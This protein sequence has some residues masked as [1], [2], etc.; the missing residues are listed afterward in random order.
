MKYLFL[1]ISLLSVHFCEAP[2]LEIGILTGQKKVRIAAQY[3]FQIFDLKDNKKKIFTRWNK[4]E[5]SFFETKHGIGFLNKKDFQRLYVK[6]FKAGPVLING[7]AYRGSVIVF[8]DKFGKLTIVNKID[9]ESYLY[10]VI[11]AEMLI[12]S[13]IEALKA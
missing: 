7:K 6:P 2:L 3:G 5:L 9:I 8:E 4:N 10:S 13:P 12:T 1:Y 11:K